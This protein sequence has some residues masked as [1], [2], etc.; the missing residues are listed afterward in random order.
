MCFPTEKQRRRE[1]LDVEKDGIVQVIN[2]YNLNDSQ[3]HLCD[4]AG[5]QFLNSRLNVVGTDVAAKLLQ[6]QIDTK[7]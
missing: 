4:S 1:G 7:N 2:S 3:G 6:K 5:N